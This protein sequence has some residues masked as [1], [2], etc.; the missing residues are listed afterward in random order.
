MRRDLVK[1]HCI[2]LRPARGSNVSRGPD[3]VPRESTLLPPLLMGAG[4][5]KWCKWCKWCNKKTFL[6]VG[7]TESSVPV[8]DFTAIDTEEDVTDEENFI[9]Y[10][11]Q[12]YVVWIVLETHRALYATSEERAVADSLVF[13]V[14]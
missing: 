5:S 6:N 11:I 10:D 14:A 13:R 3:G 12:L 9:N 8:I 7:P 4:L 2:P 1:A